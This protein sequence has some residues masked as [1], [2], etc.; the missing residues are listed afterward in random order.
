[1][2]YSYV[3]ENT[4]SEVILFPLPCIVVQIRTGTLPRLFFT[5]SIDRE[6]FVIAANHHLWHYQ[7]TERSVLQLLSVMLILGSQQTGSSAD[8]FYRKGSHILKARPCI[9]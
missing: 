1:M 5:S 4:V 8:L 3:A 7:I 2:L 6:E 9:I